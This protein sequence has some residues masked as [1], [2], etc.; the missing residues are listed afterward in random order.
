MKNNDTWIEN[1]ISDFN[2][3]AVYHRWVEV[4][5]DDNTLTK[6]ATYDPVILE[7][8]HLQQLKEFVSTGTWRHEGDPSPSWMWYL[9]VPKGTEQDEGWFP[10]PLL[11]ES[12]LSPHLRSVKEHIEILLAKV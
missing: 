2:S 6:E 11:W 8:E 7:V 3:T 1:T 5:E 12:S 9:L 4:A 10:L